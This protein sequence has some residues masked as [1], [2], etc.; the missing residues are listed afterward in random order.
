MKQDIFKTADGTKVNEVN[1]TEF[2]ITMVSFKNGRMIFT[3]KFLE[4]DGERK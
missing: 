1:M 3:I 2:V 4:S